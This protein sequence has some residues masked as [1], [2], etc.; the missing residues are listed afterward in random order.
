MRFFRPITKR[1]SNISG[2]HG[3]FAVMSGDSLSFRFVKGEDSFLEAVAV[4]ETRYKSLAGKSSVS[5]EADRINFAGM[6][7]ILKYVF[8]LVKSASQKEVTF[9]F[10]RAQREE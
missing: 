10:N 5:D 4:R 2:A 8:E 9:V 3:V 7:K 1:F 6:E